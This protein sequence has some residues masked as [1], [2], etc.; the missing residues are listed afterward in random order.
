MPVGIDNLH[1]AGRIVC[2]YAG[3]LVV[4]SVGMQVHS[5]PSYDSLDLSS[6]LPNAYVVKCRISELGSNLGCIIQ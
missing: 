4:Q 1:V 3:W 6:L 2:K 5:A